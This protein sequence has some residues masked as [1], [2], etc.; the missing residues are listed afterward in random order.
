[1]K[2][3]IRENGL[4]NVKKVDILTERGSSRSK[5]CAIA[6]F[7]DRASAAAAISRLNNSVLKGREIFVRE[8]REEGK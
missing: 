5:G 2:D 7:G 1:M 3:H 8:D 4:S 6:E